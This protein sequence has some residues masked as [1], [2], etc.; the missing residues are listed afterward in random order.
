[1]FFVLMLW[2]ESCCWLGWA[3]CTTPCCARWWSTGPLK[4]RF[5]LNWVAFSDS[6]RVLQRIFCARFV[7]WLKLHIY[8]VGSSFSMFVQHFAACWESTLLVAPVFLG[9]CVK[10]WKVLGLML[11]NYTMTLCLM[12]LNFE[13]T[14]ICA[15][16][17][18]Y[19]MH[20]VRHGMLSMAMSTATKRIGVPGQ[21][22]P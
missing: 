14:P 2:E 17:E 1:M 4:W 22:V 19:R 13:T 6:K 10:I 5:Q 9:D 12:E 15:F 11:I 20:T 21:E 8:R 16:N 18:R 7:F 3:K